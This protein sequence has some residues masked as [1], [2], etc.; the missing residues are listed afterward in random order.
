M[1]EALAC[2]TPVIAFPEGAAPEI[3]R[4]GYTG[5]LVADEHAMA[6]S[7]SELATIDPAACRADAIKRF[8][9]DQVAAEYEAVYARVAR[10]APAS[11][12]SRR[13]RRAP[14]PT[15]AAVSSGVR[16]R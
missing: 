5:F 8:D 12:G 3:V 9:K 14:V 4:H 15:P 13:R 7:V 11:H 16:L 6:A 1:V 2:G 10:V